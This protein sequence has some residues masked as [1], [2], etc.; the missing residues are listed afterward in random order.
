MLHLLL[1]FALSQPDDAGVRR[2]AIV[3]VDGCEAPLA[4]S[5]VAQVREQLAPRGAS[6]SCLL[7]LY[8]V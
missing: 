3:G 6:V 7:L 5:R 1:L 4:R 8:R 2:T